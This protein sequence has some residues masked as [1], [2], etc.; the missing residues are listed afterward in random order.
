[1]KASSSENIN[2]LREH[3]FLAANKDTSRNTTNRSIVENSSANVSKG[4]WEKL[5]YKKEEAAAENYR[6]DFNKQSNEDEEKVEICKLLNS[7][8]K[9]TLR[10]IEEKIFQIIVVSEL[11]REKF[12]DIAFSKA[13]GENTYSVL[14]SRLCKGLIE[15]LKSQKTKAEQPRSSLKGI[16]AE[17]K[18]PVSLGNELKSMLLNKCRVMF[19]EE[20][21]ASLSKSVFLTAEE[22]YEKAKSKFLGNVA[23]IS[24]LIIN[25]VFTRKVFCTCVS[26][27]LEKIANKSVEEKLQQIR[28]ECLVVLLN[29]LGSHFNSIEETKDLD[30]KK[31]EI[32]KDIY[33]FLSELEIIDKQYNLPAHIKYKIINL[34]EKSKNNWKNTLIEKALII[35]SLTEAREEYLS[36]AGKGIRDLKKE[37]KEK[38]ENNTKYNKSIPSDAQSYSNT[39]SSTSYFDENFDEQIVTK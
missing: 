14:Y 21:I 23:F 19:K 32:R 16:I 37:K 9:D 6:I 30:E 17:K 22:N 18:E 10:V 13:I 20:N 25:D 7:L 33:K 8:T 27:L 39:Y 28:I 12:L 35:K 11:S 38:L 36:E 15:R 3:K 1:M 5:D 34:V 26:F 2:Y 31:D 24:E 4:N 29:K